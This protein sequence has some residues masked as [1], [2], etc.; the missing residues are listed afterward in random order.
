MTKRVSV[1]LAICIIAAGVTAIGL[2]LPAQDPVAAPAEPA[3][4]V[5]ENAPAATDQ[6]ANSA[7]GAQTVNIKGFA[8]NGASTVQAGEQITVT[9]LD[10]AAHTLTANDGS[11]DTAVVNAGSEVTLTMPSAVGTYQYFCSLHP[12]MVSTITVQS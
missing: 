2:F 1:T 5:A 9:N 7:V 10:G 11:F 3:N 8:F 12:S 4:A 6:A